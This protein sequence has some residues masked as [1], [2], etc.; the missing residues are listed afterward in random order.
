MQTERRPKSSEGRLLTHLER[1]TVLITGGRCGCG[2]IL[3]TAGRND[4][5][6]NK[7]K[8]EDDLERLVEFSKK[9]GGIEQDV[10]EVDRISKI[11]CKSRWDY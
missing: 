4:S 2:P 3:C 1:V 9:V 6:G 11:F 7:R 5:L 10:C 8:S